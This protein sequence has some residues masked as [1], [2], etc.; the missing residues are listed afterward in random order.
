M[1]KRPI[2]ILLLALLLSVCCRLLAAQVS[3]GDLRLRVTD[4]AGLG[5]KAS[6]VV[7]AAENEFRGEFTTNDAGEA[8][9]RL[10]SYGIYSVEVS[11]AGFAAVQERVDIRSAVPTDLVVRLAVATVNTQ[12]DVNASGPIID[13]YRT[14]SVMQIGA[15]QIEDRVGSL[16]GRS[17]QDLVN[18]QPGWL[19]EGNSVL[20]PRGSEY[21]TQFVVDG[22]PL[23][24]NRSPGFGPEI[25]A[26]DLDSL[27]IYTAGIPAEYGRK[28]G[29]I[30]ELET[31]RE[32]GQGMHG[33]AVFSGGS[34]DTGSGYAAMQEA[35]GKSFLS[36]N[37]SGSL[38]AHYLNPVVPQNYTNH[39]TAGDFAANYERDLSPSDRLSLGVRHELS[40]FEIP[41]ELVQQQAGQLQTG[42]NLETMGTVRYQHIFSASSMG[43]ASGMVR[44][45][46]N[47]LNSNQ[48]STPIIAAQHNEFREGYFKATY[49]LH[50][51]H[52]EFKAGIESDS[53][54]LHENFSYQLTDPSQFDPETPAS[55]NFAAN[56]PDLEQSGFV[57]DMVRLGNWTA[58][59]G[60]RWD[61]YQLLLNQAAFSPR[62][63]VGRYIPSLNMVLHASFDRV[64]QTPS[65][66]NILISSSTQIDAL[67]DKFL[68]LPVEPSRGNYYEGGVTQ[69]YGGRAS[70]G[71]TAYRRNV[72]NFADDDQLLNTGVSYPISFA[73]AEIYGAEGKLS[74]V[75]LGR[76]NGFA[77]YS[78]MV[79]NVWYPVTGGLFLGDDASAAVGQTDGHF[80][81]SQDQRNTVRGRLEYRVTSRLWVAAGL[82]Y[83]SG[84]P[85]AYAGTED[86]ALDNYGAAVVS[87]INFARG[88]ILPSLAMNASVG[89][90][91]YKSDGCTI[92]MQA[93]GDDLNGRL[94][95][96]DFGGLF[97]GNAIAPGRSFAVRLKTNF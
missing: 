70:V 57:E 76:F 33:Q 30:V 71:V 28:M 23:T 90:D 73:K 89:A 29:G 18:S 64:F 63:S 7:S 66:E 47:D 11:R 81:A 78:Y 8:S 31:H 75:K 79:A 21:Q 87:R 35:W 49:S 3:R 96:L 24:D 53:T 62:L 59:A 60:L 41:N 82:N 56:R 1:P 74:L 27:S 61:H 9:V 12:V 38:S 37:A 39:G 2:S 13:P 46:A 42:D 92:R 95:V 93:D 4:S 6:V 94:N 5:I 67:S 45:T 48:R 65:F 44:D 68:R 22:I 34:Y 50:H 84:L 40:R 55:L 32:T 15:Q 85:F 20:H 77:S 83:G 26:D 51:G 10:L 17:V 97:S 36:L 80:P 16:P 58:S 69:A 86:E 91:L 19:Y 14:S 43:T 54:F 88:R 25:E 72:A 52:H